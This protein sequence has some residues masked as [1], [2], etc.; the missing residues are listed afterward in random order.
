MYYNRITNSAMQ[1]NVV[2]NLLTNRNKL[3]QLQEEISS[4]EQVQEP[5]DNPEAAV[6]IL[7]SN[8]SLDKINTYQS[9][10]SNATSELN[11]TDQALQSAVST[12]TNAKDLA[13]QAASASTDPTQLKALG[14]QMEQYL[15]TIKDLGNT[16]FGSK[17]IFGGT[18]T[19]NPPFQ[20]GTNTGET[21]YTGTPSTGNYQRNV[22]ISDNLSVPI[23][24]A[25]DQ[26]FGQYYTDPTTNT[27]VSSGVIGTLTTLTNELNS[28]NPDQNAIRTQL[29]NLNTDISNLSN[30][31]GTIGATMSR[32]D[33]TKTAL[34]NDS[35]T[36]TQFKSNA[37]DIDLAKT[38]SDLQ[39]QETALQASLQVSAQIIQ[40]SL[41]TYMNF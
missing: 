24:L 22:Q 1:A 29:D 17:Y 39:S 10:I 40:P 14:S 25:G 41:L 23:N 2:Q 9:N 38:I 16:Q 4:G 12:V 20:N 19:E 8:T 30:S 13:V 18:N 35:N 33:T 11:V 3:N 15:Q 28:A 37:Q 21:Q 26:V 34:T 36:I 32:L 7:N 5:S 6:E 27:V 31:D